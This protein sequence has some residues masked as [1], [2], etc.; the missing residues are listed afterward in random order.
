MR[1][2][3]VA[4][5][6]AGERLCQL[7]AGVGRTPRETLQVFRHNFWEVRKL[8]QLRGVHLAA[9]GGPLKKILAALTNPPRSV[10]PDDVASTLV[11]RLARN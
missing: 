5:D 1:Q 6:H 4:G 7:G 3:G 9:F 11:D 10:M 8:L 2:G